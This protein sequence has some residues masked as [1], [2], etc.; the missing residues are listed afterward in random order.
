GPELL[1]R[2]QEHAGK[3]GVP[4]THAEVQRITKLAD[5]SFRAESAQGAWRGRFVLLATG[6]RDVE[7]EIEGLQDAMLAGQVRYC[8]VCDGFETQGQRVAVLGRAGHGL[9][10]S[11]FISNFGNH[12]TWLA[13]ESEEEVAHEHLEQLRGAGI[14]IAGSAPR[15]IA[16]GDGCGVRVEL[17]SG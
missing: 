6:A 3:Y 16:C 15:I 2:M 10:E 5:G 12:V 1:R 13:M 4:T 14:R 11:L 17:H 9:R 7:P 8:P